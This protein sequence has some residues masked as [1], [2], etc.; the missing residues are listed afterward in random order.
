M[1]EGAAHATGARLYWREDPGPAPDAPAL[2]LL[3]SLAS[4]HRMWD[5]QVPLLTRR[6]RVIRMDTRG[7][8][9]SEAPEGDYDFPT[10]VGDAAAVLD[11]AGAARATVMGLS[12]GGM[13]ALGLGIYQAARVDRIVCCD[14]RADAPEPFVRSWEDRLAALRTGGM[15]ALLPGTIERWLH[16]AF[17]AAH[18][19]EVERVSAM[20]LATPPAGYAGCV[21]ALKR[22]DYLRDLHRIP[23]PTLFVC[24]A[25][26]MAA[27]PA[28]MRDMAA[29]IPGA[30]FVEVPRA[31]HLP[32]MDNAEGFAEAV[33]GF[34]GLR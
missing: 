31:A 21:A 22:L 12:L 16:P 19:G 11:A 32:N 28:T 2:L 34:L 8:G 29:R 26:D 33:S 15:A 17:R 7:H 20:I 30:R 24:G 25:E 4:D 9:R 5:G 10:L 3:N 13:T 18:P 1:R 23:V 6:Y 27:P 14:A